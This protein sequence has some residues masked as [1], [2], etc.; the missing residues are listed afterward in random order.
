M[1]LNDLKGDDQGEVGEFALSFHFDEAG[2][3]VPDG[4]KKAENKEF[5]PEELAEAY[6]LASRELI[7]KQDAAAG[8]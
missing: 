5:T 1:N 3:I 2:N 7:S 8:H 4:W 6:V